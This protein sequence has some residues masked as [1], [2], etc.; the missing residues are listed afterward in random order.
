VVTRAD[1]IYDLTLTAADSNVYI[2]DFNSPK[3]ISGAGINSGKQFELIGYHQEGES[4]T[5][6]LIREIADTFI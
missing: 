5:K 3:T 2:S 4:K 6:W 1:S